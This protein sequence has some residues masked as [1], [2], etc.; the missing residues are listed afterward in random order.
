M[1]KFH[2]N[3]DDVIKNSENYS[4]SDSDLLNLT[5][6]KVKVLS[7]SDLENYDTID[8]VLDPFG[9]AI[10]LYQQ[11][12]NSGHWSSIIKQKNN[13]IEIFDSL[14]VA[15]DH[16]L[17]FSDYNKKRHSGIAVPH[18]TNLLNKS[19]YEVEV[20][21]RQ[22]QNDSE[23]INTCGRWAGLRVRFRDIPMKKFIDM[24]KN[25][26]NDPDYMVTALTIL[27]S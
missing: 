22:I 16:E 17:D 14:G 2:N 24:F 27:F 12:K 8:E 25:G 21:L 18:L 9:T 10:I 20:N 3:I 13:T 11:T 23:Q 5:D 15:L 7:Y 6:D 1:N 4:L 26:K 19:K